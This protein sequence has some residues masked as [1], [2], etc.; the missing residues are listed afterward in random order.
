MLDQRISVLKSPW[1]L[2]NKMVLNCH[3]GWLL[4]SEAVID[5]SCHVQVVD[6]S[7]MIWY[8]ISEMQFFLL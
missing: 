7:Q 1:T 2:R 6:I 8:H 4:A 5:R 3:P